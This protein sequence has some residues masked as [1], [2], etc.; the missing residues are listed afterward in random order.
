MGRHARAATLGLGIG[1]GTTL[2]ATA[3]GTLAFFAN[4]EDLATQGFL[5]PKR[6]KDGWTLRFDH[7]FVT[8]AEIAAHQAEPPYDAREGGPIEAVATVGLDGIRTLDLVQGDA[9]DRLLVAAVAAPE[10][11]FNAISWRMAPAADGPHAGYA[12]VFV[13]TAERDGA[14]VPFVL[15]SGETRAYRC[16]EYVGDERKGFVVAGSAADVELTF[17]LDHVFG[18]ADRPADDPTNVAA[19]GFDPFASGGDHQILLEGLHIG[20]AGE[21]HCHVVAD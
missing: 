13:G 7:V 16:G 19:L 5:E 12:I 3:E 2:P 6:T 9:D 4:G 10:G 1:L 15:R 8:L 17:H 11:H 14:T 21:G 20:H 18:R